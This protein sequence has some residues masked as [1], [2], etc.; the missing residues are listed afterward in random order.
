MYQI[1]VVRTV[2]FQHDVLYARIRCKELQAIGHHAV[3]C[4]AL[5]IFYRC[6]ESNHCRRES[7]SDGDVSCQSLFVLFTSGLQK[8]SPAANMSK[9]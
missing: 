2:L 5:A 3:S 1:Q 6:S 4:T 8:Q 9:E 7:T